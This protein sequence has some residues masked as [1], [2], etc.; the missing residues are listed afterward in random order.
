MNYYIIAFFLFLLISFIILLKTRITIDNHQIIDKKIAQTRV[1]VPAIYE[2]LYTRDTNNINVWVLSKATADNSKLSNDIA[3]NRVN[4]IIANGRMF[5][6]KVEYEIS[7]GFGIRFE[8]VCIDSSES[9][10]Q[11][12]SASIDDSNGTKIFH[13]LGYLI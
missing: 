6:V 3:K 7:D 11:C 9:F 8:D 13:V 1:L 12:K 2:I 4:Y 5:K 10:F